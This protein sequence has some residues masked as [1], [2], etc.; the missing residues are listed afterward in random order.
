MSVEQRLTEH[1]DRQAAP[2]RA[3][4][5]WEELSGRVDRSNRNRRMIL[6][7]GILLVGAAIAVPLSQTGKTD[8]R[9][10][11]EVHSPLEQEVWK[12]VK[13]EMTG[14]VEVLTRGDNEGIAWEAFAFPTNRGTCFGVRQQ[15]ESNTITK[16]VRFPDGAYEC[17][18]SP[19]DS[20]TGRLRSLEREPAPTDRDGFLRASHLA[21]NVLLPS[22]DDVALSVDGESRSKLPILSPSFDRSLRF[23][24]VPPQKELR[25]I[26]L[27]FFSKGKPIGK[28]VTRVNA[29]WVSIALGSR[30]VAVADDGR[31]FR[32]SFNVGKSP[33]R[34]AFCTTYVIQ[35]TDPSSRSL[36]TCGGTLSDP[37]GWT[38][39]ALS[40][41]TKE[42]TSRVRLTMPDGAVYDTPTFGCDLGAPICFFGIDLGPA[43]KGSRSENPVRVEGFSP[44]RTKVFHWKR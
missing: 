40:G 36:G 22:Q 2:I 11:K 43:E 34:W 25:P 21:L 26:T 33:D 41:Q 23:V 32:V 30:L 1:F 27:S 37:R 17:E 35:T 5:D 10:A 7:V 20:S 42:G 6:A 13:H 24:V 12:P 3:N 28:P 15:H 9:T 38:G 8:V 18:R 14:D 31:E 39:N 19:S 4:P 44:N 29:A 16:D